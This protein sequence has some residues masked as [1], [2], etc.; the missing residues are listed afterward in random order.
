MLANSHKTAIHRRKP[1]AP[2]R[3]LYEND[4]IVCPILDW[5]CGLM[6]DAMFLLRNTGM[7]YGY[8]PHYSPT[9]PAQGE[10][11]NT[12]LC[13]YVL[14]TIP[15]YFDRCKIVEESLQYLARGGWLYVSIRSRPSDL[16]G[17]TKRGTWQGYVGQQLHVGGFDLV[18]N[19]SDFEIWGWQCS[20]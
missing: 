12:V 4:K 16:L 17:W 3:W 9:P 20:K 15:G 10:K 13:T 19:V 14:N 8:D 11:F 5:G 6:A 7:V 18:A 1:S 2:C